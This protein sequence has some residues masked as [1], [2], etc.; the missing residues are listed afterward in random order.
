[1]DWDKTYSVEEVLESL[2]QTR[3]GPRD[4]P[5]VFAVEKTAA[6]RFHVYPVV[7]KD[8]DANLVPRISIMN[9]DVSFNIQNIDGLTFVESICSKLS[10]LTKEKV[11]LGPVPEN[12]LETL[13]KEISPS[14]S[15]ADQ[16]ARDCLGQFLGK[17]NADISW[18]L[19]FNPT[20]EQYELMLYNK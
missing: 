17:I 2:M 6:N 11:V 9:R 19:L 15:I 1:M 18:Q 8:A 5:A 13:R 10:Y 12:L 16:K 3:I 14:V 7:A 4:V 20:L